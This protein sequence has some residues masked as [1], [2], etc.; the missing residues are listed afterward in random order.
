MMHVFGQPFQPDPPGA[1]IESWARARQVAAAAVAHVGEWCPGLEVD[2]HLVEGNAAG[3]LVDASR[4]AE[5]LVVGH[6]GLSGFAELLTGSV[7][8][9]TTSHAHCPVLVVRGELGEPHA[10]VIVG[11]DGSMPA[12]AATEVA[13]QEA[14][15]RGSELV[16]AL[17]W[18]PA[19][20]W[21]AAITAAGLP[22]HPDAIDPI[23][24]SL[25]RI[26]ARYPDVKV[27]REVRHGDSPA[28]VIGELAIWE[29]AGLI[30]VGARG[31]GGFHGLLMGGT[32]RALVDHAPCPLMVIPAGRRQ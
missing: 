21:P 27:R 5:F 24:V 31:A 25:G 19:R 15:L 2:I 22:P 23:E 29:D 32:C 8:V 30:V 26:S 7:G 13:F 17:A 18:P 10:P 1:R 12:R 11:V 6:R 9:H 14:R 3:A 20:S 4:D 28:Q 16:V